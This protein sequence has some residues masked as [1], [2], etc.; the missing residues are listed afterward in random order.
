MSRKRG[1][2]RLADKLASVLAEKLPQEV[3]DDLR[4][5]RVPA[6]QILRMFTPD[7]DPV[8]HCHGGS[9]LWWNLTM[10]LR[11]GEVLAKNKRDTSIAAKVKRITPEQEALRRALLKPSTG[12]SRKAAKKKKHKWASRPFSR[13]HK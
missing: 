5:R 1:H 12:R 8:L 3:R 6:E 7:H 2:I 4:A 9:D 13:G 11:D 10:R